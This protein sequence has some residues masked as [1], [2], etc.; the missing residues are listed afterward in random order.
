MTWRD[1]YFELYQE[2]QDNTQM[3]CHIG[4]LDTKVST[5]PGTSCEHPVMIWTDRFVYFSYEYDG[6]DSLAVVPRHFKD[7]DLKK[8]FKHMEGRKSE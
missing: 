4:D 5:T 8:S 1:L 3:L 7:F 6:I 2:L